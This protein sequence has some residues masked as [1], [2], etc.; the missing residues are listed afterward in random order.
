MPIFFAFY[1]LLAQAVELW[2]APWALW[3]SDLSVRDPYYVLP[4][5]MGATQLVQQRMMPAPPNPTQRTIMTMMP[6]M[7]TVFALNFPAGLVLYWLTNNLLTIVQQ[8]GYNRL[9]KS[10]RFGGT[11]TAKA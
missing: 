4:L 5:V 3:I 2:G 6:V 9:K 8:G 11:Q 7:F 1:Q 10:G